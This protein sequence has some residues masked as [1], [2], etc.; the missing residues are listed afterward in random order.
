MYPESISDYGS[1]VVP[2]LFRTPEHAEIVRVGGGSVSQGAAACRLCV[3]E[4]N[5]I[6]GGCCRQD[7]RRAGPPETR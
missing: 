4:D 5:R 3:C 2:G 7:R 6:E 1:A